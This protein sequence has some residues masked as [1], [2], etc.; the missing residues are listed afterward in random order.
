[1]LPLALP[2]VPLVRLQ[3]YPIRAT[4]SNTKRAPE[5]IVSSA[6]RTHAQ[7]H[8]A[9]RCAATTATRFDDGGIGGVG[10]E[11]GNEIEI[12]IEK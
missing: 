12:D 8:T 2:C 3:H 1:M 4:Q 7:A 9:H 5:F 6:Q 11:A 10:G